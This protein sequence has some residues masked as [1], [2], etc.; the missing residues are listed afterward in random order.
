MKKVL[1]P[2]F[3]VLLIVDQTTKI[4]V[5]NTFML[6]ET[7]EV[8]PGF[9]N[10]T[11]ILN[12]GAAFGFLAKMNESY[13]QLFFVL[14]TLIAIAAVGYLLYKEHEMKLRAFSYTLIIAGAVGNFIDR[15]YIGKVV[16]FLD[17]YVS[18]YHWP[19][20]NVADSAISVGVCLLMLDLFLHKRSEK[21]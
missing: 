1:I 2:L 20:F 18:D 14:V 16:D 7:R 6:H 12:P 13:R 5:K 9:F 8:I 11:Y 3:A 19:A 4:I 17:F 10:L 15:V 21:K